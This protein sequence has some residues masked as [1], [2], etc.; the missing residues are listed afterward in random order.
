MHIS[1]TPTRVVVTE[2]DQNGTYEREYFCFTAIDLDLIE[3]QHDAS[4]NGL[5]EMGINRLSP[6]VFKNREARDGKLQAL[7]DF[8]RAGNGKIDTK[9]EITITIP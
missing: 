8:M 2:G 6:E 3:G 5:R 9:P 4:S 7:E 1:A